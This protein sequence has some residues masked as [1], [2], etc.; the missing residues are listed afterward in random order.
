MPSDA[1][2]ILIVDDE[3]DMRQFVEAALEEDGYRLCVASDG[4]EALAQVAAERPDLIVMDVQMPRKDGLTALYDLRRD[5]ATKSIP[6]V[7]LTGV[8]E[9]TG[10]RF[11][12]ESVE[13]YMGERPEAFFD[14][15]V[16]PEE[17]R[18]AV[19]DLVARAPRPQ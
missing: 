19:A 10:V 5:P 12:A 15:P 3:P 8:S 2:T 14:K 6:V 4:E 7:L 18:R 9:K 11:S 1:P 13:E 17:L 16:D